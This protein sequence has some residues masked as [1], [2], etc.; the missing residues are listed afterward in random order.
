MH[1]AS[2][3]VADISRT[4]FVELL[5]DGSYAASRLTQAEPAGPGGPGGGDTTLPRATPAR[6][7]TLPRRAH[8]HIR[9]RPYPVHRCRRPRSIRHRGQVTPRNLMGFKDGTANFTAEDTAQV[10]AHVWASGSDSQSWMTNG[11]YLVA[12]KIRMTIET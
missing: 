11:S 10:N 12:R 8:D 2:F 6:P 7:S 1:F 5:E 9:I 3:D 4:E